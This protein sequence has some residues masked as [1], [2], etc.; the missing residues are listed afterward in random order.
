MVKKGHDGPVLRIRIRLLAGSRF[1]QV[2]GSV[3]GLD[4]DLIRS[5]DP[6]LDP[7]GTKLPTKVEKIKKFYVLDVVFCGLKASSVVFLIQ[8]PGSGS[9]SVF[10]LKCWI[11]I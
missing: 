4:Q 2:K 5:V 8:N 9:G 11:W 10:G 3:S 6:D 1:Y 7:E